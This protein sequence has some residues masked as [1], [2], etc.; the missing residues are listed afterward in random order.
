MGFHYPCTIAP[1]NISDSI[2]GAGETAN[3]HEKRKLHKYRELQKDYLVVPIAVE[4]FG[5]FGQQGRKLIDEIGN[6]IIE[7]SGEKRS[8]FYLY[9]RISMAIQ[10][11]NVAS[12]LGTVEQQEKLNE[13][14]NLVT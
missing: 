7:K 8:K 2:K 11:G 10:R 6:M 12:V 5:S 13:I 14:F 9:Q 4:T 1:S 3:V